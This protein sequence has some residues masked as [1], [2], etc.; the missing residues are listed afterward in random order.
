MHQNQRTL[1][2]ALDD[3]VEGSR[4]RPIALICAVG[5]RSAFLQGW[6]RKAGFENVFDVTEGMVG[7][8]RGAG[9]IKTGLPVRRWVPG[10]TKPHP[11]AP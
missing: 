9:W 6:L 4:R 7:G 11:G 2:Q 1:L 3:A 5:N 8:R 10:A